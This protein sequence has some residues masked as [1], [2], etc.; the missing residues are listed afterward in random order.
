MV[1]HKWTDNF[2]VE[3]VSA[4]PSDN[5]YGSLSVQMLKITKNQFEKGIEITI[6]QVD[7]T[8]GAPFLYIS[9]QLCE[10][11]KILRDRWGNE[12]YSA[13]NKN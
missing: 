11:S 2:L 6:D 9:I 5:Y 4:R 1:G 12:H 13:E 8:Y 3:I 7:I 10:F